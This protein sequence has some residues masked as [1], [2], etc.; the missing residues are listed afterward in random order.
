MK[1]LHVW[2]AERGVQG[3]QGVEEFKE[4]QN[5]EP[6]GRRVIRPRCSLYSLYSSY[7]SYSLDSF[8]ET[9]PAKIGIQRY[10]ALF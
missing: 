10:A 3:V 4:E 2:M 8:L 9:L 5:Q 6:G 1:S 7:S